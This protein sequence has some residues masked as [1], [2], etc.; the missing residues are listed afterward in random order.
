VRQRRVTA[1]KLSKPHRLRILQAGAAK[2][3]NFC[4]LRCLAVQ[5]R[6]QFSH[7]RDQRS[8][9]CVRRNLEGGR[10][11]VVGRLRRVDVVIRMNHI[12]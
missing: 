8:E 1:K 2:V 12:V 7:F 11:H 3:E 6:R 5:L 9:H 10:I 4:K